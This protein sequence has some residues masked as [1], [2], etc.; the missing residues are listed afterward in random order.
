M[1]CALVMGRR[2]PG[3]GENVTV[4]ESS[5]GRAFRRDC[6]GG[7]STMLSLCTICGARWMRDTIS[8]VLLCVIC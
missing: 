5:V 6:L 8:G 3:M 7:G 2:L 1:I 4:V